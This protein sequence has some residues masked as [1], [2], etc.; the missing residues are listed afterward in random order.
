MNAK[1]V[2]NAGMYNGGTLARDDDE[3]FKRKTAV[4]LLAKPGS[5][6]ENL[7]ERIHGLSSSRKMWARE[8]WRI[9]RENP[10]GLSSKSGIPRE[11]RPSH[12]CRGGR[13]T[14]TQAHRHALGGGNRVNKFILEHDR[15]NLRGS[16]CRKPHSMKSRHGKIV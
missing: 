7:G 13:E 12:S 4:C 9:G 8:K 16:K 10:S 14:G 15:K 2:S 1:P 3:N 5:S 11:D 6:P